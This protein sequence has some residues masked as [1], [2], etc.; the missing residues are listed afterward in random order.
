[1]NNK[2]RKKRS[3]HRT[4]RSIYSFTFSFNKQ[5]SHFQTSNCNPKFQKSSILLLK[6]KVEIKAKFV[7]TVPYKFETQLIK[8]N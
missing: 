8:I 1:M 7:I 6:K 5:K 4:G 2:K 3:A